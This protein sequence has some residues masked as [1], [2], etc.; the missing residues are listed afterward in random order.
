M[1]RRSYFEQL[2]II[3]LQRSRTV[4]PGIS[5]LFKGTKGNSAPLHLLKG[6]AKL[7][8]LEVPPHFSTIRF[9]GM[10]KTEDRY[11]IIPCDINRDE[12]TTQPFVRKAASM[13][14]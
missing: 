12:K 13:D 3:Q 11:L 9:Q 7:L 6:E 14:C 1:G 5:L 4:K 8:S 10:E 2:H